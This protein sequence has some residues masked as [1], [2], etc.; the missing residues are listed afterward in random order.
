MSLQRTVF[1][2]LMSSYALMLLAG[3][4]LVGCIAVGVL[5]SNK[6]NPLPFA[7]A[8]FAFGIIR[9]VLARWLRKLGGAPQEFRQ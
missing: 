1:F 9:F 4:G 8:V 3:L 6:I 2:A 7:V 5:A